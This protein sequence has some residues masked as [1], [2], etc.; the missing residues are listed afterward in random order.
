VGP[1]AFEWQH[2]GLRHSF[3]SYR[4]ATVSNVAQVALEAGNTMAA[5]EATLNGNGVF[6]SV[7]R[8][9]EVFAQ[10]DD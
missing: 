3:I 5:V 1:R 2:N 7:S 8:V 9:R 10:L 6:L 4:V